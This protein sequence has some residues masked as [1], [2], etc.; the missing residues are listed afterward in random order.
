METI[1][2]IAVAF[3]ITMY[4]LLDGFDLGAGAI[5]LAAAKNDRERRTIIRAI[6]PV[7]D[8][9]EVWLIAAGGTLFFAFPL[10]YASSFS[11][12]YLPLIIVLW[13]LMIRGLAVELRGHLENPLWASFWDAAFFFGSSLLI[14]FYGAALGNVV[15]GV[16]LN[17]DGY[18]FQPLW[19]DFSPF[20]EE[21]GILDWYTVLIGLLAFTT[22]TAHGANWIALKTEGALNA[23]SRRISLTFSLATAALTLVA[24]PATFW[25]SPWMLEGFLERPY[26]LVLPLL[27]LAGLAGMILLPLSGRDRPAFFASGAY[28]L[29]ML[30]STV[31][32]VY[33][34]VLPAV[35]PQNS[36]TIQNAASS[37]Y[38]QA[39]GLAWWSI[40]MVLAAVYFVLIY[41]LFRG[42]VNPEDEGY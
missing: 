40:G 30:G 8:G 7:W 4:V 19:T 9:N 22:L 25:V 27:A 23:R 17:A 13:L 15:R 10:L 24:T 31:F 1:W 6:G 38:S 21:P 2:F 37:D 18:F 11:G 33:P 3:M 20:S 12:F 32:A 29:G 39:V 35:D 16:P 34:R 36:L 28:V 5:H 14:V 41:R 42:K 26:G